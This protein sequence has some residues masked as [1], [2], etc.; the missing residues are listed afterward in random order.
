MRASPLFRQEEIEFERDRSQRPERSSFST[1]W[2]S[3]SVAVRSTM[4]DMEKD[5]QVSVGVDQRPKF[6]R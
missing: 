1:L 5:D 6:V 2:M 3:S 4:V